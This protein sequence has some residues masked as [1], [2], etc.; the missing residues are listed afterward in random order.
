M[1]LADEIGKL[2]KLHDSG[3]LTDAEF[4]QAK[5]A[6]LAGSASTGRSVGGSGSD[7]AL[8][9]AAK[10]WVN[11]QIVM[12]IVGVILALIFIF[13]FFLPNWNKSQDDVDRRWNEFPGKF[14]TAK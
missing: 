6:L 13:G 14:P 11:F 1:E 10:T 7:D 12:A 9:N 4:A 5:S 3:D 8:G 2:K